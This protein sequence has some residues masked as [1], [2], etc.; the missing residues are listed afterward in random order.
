M[1]SNSQSRK[2]TLI[3]N[4]PIESAGLDH[5]VITE[6][7]KRFSPDYFCMADERAPTTGTFHTHIF[8][9]SKSPIRFSTLK[10]RFPIAH[11]EKAYGT[12]KENLEYITKEGRWKDHK[13]ETSIPNSFVEFGTM[14]NEH[15]ETS[16]KT[17]QLIQQ[18]KEGRKVADLINDFPEYALKIKDI[19]VLRQTILADRFSQ[20]MRNVETTYLYGSNGG[21]RTRSIYENHDP[22][23]ICRI[24][25]YSKGAALFD[26]YNAGQDVLV[27]EDFYSQISIEEMV[28]YIVPFPI[29][30]PARYQNRIGCYTKVYISS[31]IPLELQ[32]H[33]VQLRYPELWKSF[34]H[35][36]HHVIEYRADGT[37]RQLDLK[38]GVIQ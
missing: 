34:L 6:I 37:I 9:Y 27:F 26:S 31:N 23:E 22:R 38:G 14:P 8:V 28:S 3:L 30:L 1:G 19:E 12:A 5:E 10:S 24:T 33:M 36:I 32:Y 15:E 18:I 20:I 35:R 17:Y 11:I 25:N 21:D 4:N 13:S 29:N 16:P 7:L 2:W